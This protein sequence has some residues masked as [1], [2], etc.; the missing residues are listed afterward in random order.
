MLYFVNRCVLLCLSWNSDG[1]Q[2]TREHF[3]VGE[4]CH[5]R[6]RLYH[7]MRHFK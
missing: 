4:L 3:Y 6:I 1:L 7:A 5:R 2:Y